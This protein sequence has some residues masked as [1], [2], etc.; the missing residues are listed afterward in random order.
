[1]AL[2][3]TPKDRKKKRSLPGGATAS[4]MRK[5][6]AHAKDLQSRGRGRSAAMKEAWRK[7][8]TGDL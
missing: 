4:D 3:P 5:I 2:K 7:Y 1:M 6:M 8:K